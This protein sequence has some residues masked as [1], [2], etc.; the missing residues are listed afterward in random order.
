[1][2]SLFIIAG[3]NG[4]GKST[5]SNDLLAKEG[6]T[7][8]DYDMEL[9]NAWSNFS[10]DPAI[11][12]GVRQSISSRFT[13]L[14]SEALLNKTSFAYE[15]NY[16][17]AQINT[18]NLFRVAGHQTH[19]IFLALPNVAQAMDRVK[20]RAA[21]GGHNVDE[22]TIKERFIAGLSHLDNSFQDF[23]TVDIYES[24]EKKNRLVCTLTP[25]LKRVTI[26]STLSPELARHLPKIEA[27]V[28]SLR[29]DYGMS[30]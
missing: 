2:P 24:H 20:D 13:D 30:M 9:R 17:V 26:Q 16:N 28:R 8:F 14:K 7:A 25:S 29:R 1:M 15:T 11:E 10:F 19:L 23:D 5:T 12:D 6:I 3:P 4:A 27:F 22:A 18:V 21:K